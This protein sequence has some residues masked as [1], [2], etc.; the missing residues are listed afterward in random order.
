MNNLNQKENPLLYWCSKIGDF[1]VLSVL[2]LLMCIPVLTVIPA[3][4]A[5]FDSIAHCIHGTEDGTVRRFFRT[6]KNE[7]L[8]GILLSLIWLVVG[9][10]LAYGYT[11]LHQMGL[12][13]EVMSTYSKVYLVSMLIP[14]GILTWLIPVESRFHHSFLGLFRAAIAYSI[15]HLPTT[16]LL[17]V[18]F[19]VSVILVYFLPVLAVLMP[20]ISVTVQCW[21]VE[22]IFKRYI[23]QKEEEN[24]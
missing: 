7:L 21:F 16:I 9:C 17:L 2:W 1:C 3:C 11:I 12:E 10:G 15:G 23:P 18:I 24:D 19:A 6:F 13:N 5:L 8:R 14:M 20:A 22:K 4:I